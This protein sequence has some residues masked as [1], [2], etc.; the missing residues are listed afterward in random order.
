MLFL[1]F[2][3]GTD[4]Y[5]LDARRIVE[6]LPL[7]NLKQLPQAPPGV[8]GLFTYRGEPVPVLDLCELATGQPAQRRLSTRLVVVHYPSDSPAPQELGLIVERATES[9]RREPG[10][11]TDPGL[12]PPDAPYLGPVTRDERG[13]I[14]RVEVEQL[15]TPTLRELLF[16][17]AKPA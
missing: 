14:Q 13:L 3:L 17:S 7:V 2:E 16:A 12:A 15:L 11:F 4:R 8:A 9:L 5:A 1:L 10:D 6:V